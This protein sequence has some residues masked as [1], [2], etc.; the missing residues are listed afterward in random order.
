[1]NAN[2]IENIQYFIE[3]ITKKKPWANK[4]IK[5]RY[6]PEFVE[7]SFNFNSIKIKFYFISNSKFKLNI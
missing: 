4:V 5:K 7:V 2:K 1:M 6:F 3:I